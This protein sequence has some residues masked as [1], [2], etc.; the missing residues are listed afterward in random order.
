MQKI[1]EDILK[2]CP[3]PLISRKEAAKLTGGLISEK[4]LANLDCEG[5]GPKGR[6]HIGRRAGYQSDFFVLW[7]AERIN[8]KNY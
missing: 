8:Q 2:S 4:Y 1:I 7:L 3:G 6:I 5:K